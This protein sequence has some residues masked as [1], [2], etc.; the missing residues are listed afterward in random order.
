M[1]TTDATIISIRDRV[2]ISKQMSKVLRH[3]AHDFG[4]SIRN[5][6]YMEGNVLLNWLKKK[7]RQPI[8]NLLTA[9][10]I[11]SLVLHNK[12]QRFHLLSDLD[13]DTWYVR[14]NQGHSMVG[15]CVDMR[16]VTDPS[17]IPNCIHG[18]YSRHL[19]DIMKTGLNRMNRQ[20]I[21]MAAS[22]PEKNGVISGMR[23]SCDTII[24]VD[25]AKAMALGIQFFISSNGVIL[26]P[27]DPSGSIPA[28]CFDRVE[29]R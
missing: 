14:A 5:D 24:Y 12:K 18:T 25:A 16:E 8:K 3:K 7:V 19:N 11:N 26:S 4:L 1:N 27:G 23:N 21:H 9:G 6:G 13:E 15:I 22:V 20:H 17:E 2:F 10:L 29:Q 28:S